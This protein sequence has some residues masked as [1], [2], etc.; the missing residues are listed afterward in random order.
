MDLNVNL[1]SHPFQKI[2]TLWI[3]DEIILIIIDIDFDE[4][5]EQDGK[6]D[7]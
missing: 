6:F 7:D 2:G 5:L 1:I 3:Y 4:T